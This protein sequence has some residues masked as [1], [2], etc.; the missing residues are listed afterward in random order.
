MLR[1]LRILPIIHRAVNDNR[2][3]LFKCFFQSR[4]QFFGTVDP[5]SDGMHTFCEFYKIRVG[6]VYIEVFPIPVFLF[7]FDQAIAA[8][9]KDQGYKR[10]SGAQGS[11]KFLAVHH[12][13]AITSNRQYLFIRVDQLGCQCTRNS[14]SHGGKAIGN[15]TGIWLITVIMPC[16]PHFMGTYIR[17][18]DIFFSHYLAHII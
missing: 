9:I 17:N 15:N 12:K 3:L 14:N 13:T 2:Y 1:K 18:N 5:I 11:L 6:K 7:P 16:D 4:D 8:I 10:S